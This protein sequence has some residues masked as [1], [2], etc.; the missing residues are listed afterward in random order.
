MSLTTKEIRDEKKIEI[1]ESIIQQ[2]TI[3]YDLPTGWQG[4]ELKILSSTFRLEPEFKKEVERELISKLYEKNPEKARAFEI[5]F[6]LVQGPI[7]D[8]KFFP[9]NSFSNF[10]KGIDEVYTSFDKKNIEWALKNKPLLEKN[11]IE[12]L[13]ADE[14]LILVNKLFIPKIDKKTSDSLVALLQSNPDKA[15]TIWNYLTLEKE[16]ARNPDKFLHLEN[17]KV[18]QEIQAENLETANKHQFA[19]SLYREISLQN[20][21]DEFF[22]KAMKQAR[23]LLKKGQIDDAI[24]TI[25][26]AGLHVVIQGQE[27]SAMFQSFLEKA[28]IFIYK[29]EQEKATDISRLVMQYIQFSKVSNQIALLLSSGQSNEVIGASV[30]SIDIFQENG[31][32]NETKFFN[33]TGVSFETFKNEGVN[34]FLKAIRRKALQLSQLGMKNSIDSIRNILKGKKID[35]KTDKILSSITELLGK[36]NDVEQLIN[37][38]WKI[39]GTEARLLKMDFYDVSG[40]KARGF[41]LNARSDA[42]GSFGTIQY[43]YL[44]ALINRVVGIDNTSILKNIPNLEKTTASKIQSLIR[45]YNISINFESYARAYAKSMEDYHSSMIKAF[46]N[47]RNHGTELYSKLKNTR[48]GVAPSLS[49]AI[50]DNFNDT[51]LPSLDI[52]N[53]E[54]PLALSITLSSYTPDAIKFNEAKTL[55][56]MFGENPP[57]ISPLLNLVNKMN[58]SGKEATDDYKGLIR[59]INTALYDLPDTRGE[60]ER[61][62]TDPVFWVPIAIA[63]MGRGPAAAAAVWRVLP[64]SVRFG[65]SAGATAY[66]AIEIGEG[67]AGLILSTSNKESEEAIGKMRSGVFNTGMGLLGLSSL[68]LMSKTAITASEIATLGLGSFVLS[69]DIELM[70]KEGKTKPLTLAFDL[71][72]L[73]PA[74]PLAVKGFKAYQLASF[75]ALSSEYGVLVE[76][77]IGTQNGKELLANQK[78]LEFLGKTP[79]EQEAILSALLSIGKN[80]AVAR[81]YYLIGVQNAAKNGLISLD[82]AQK[83]S[84]AILQESRL[85]VSESGLLALYSSLE[86]EGSIAGLSNAYKHPGADF[87]GVISSDVFTLISEGKIL[88]GGKQIPKGAI[89]NIEF[90][91]GGKGAFNLTIK[92]HNGETTSVIMKLEDLTAEQFGSQLVSQAGIVSPQVMTHSSGR[93]LTYLTPDGPRK[94]GLIEHMGNV[95]T[96]VDGVPVQISNMETM[97]DLSK[98]LE[99][100]IVASLKQ[101]DSLALRRIILR[102]LGYVQTG[103]IN[104]G[105]IDGTAANLPI[106]LGKIDQIGAERLLSSSKYL[107]FEEGITASGSLSEQIGKETLGIVMKSSDGSYYL[108][109][110]KSSIGRFDCE[111]SAMFYAAKTS[112]GYDFSPTVS[113]FARDS[114]SSIQSINSEFGQVSGYSTNDM[115]LDIFLGGQHWYRNVGSLPEFR[116]AIISRIAAHNGGPIGFATEGRLPKGFVSKYLSLLEDGKI[117]PKNMEELQKWLLSP[118]GGQSAFD[119]WIANVHKISSIDDSVRQNYISVLSMWIRQRYINGKDA[120]VSLPDGRISLDSQAAIQTFENLFAEGQATISSGK[121]FGYT[122]WNEIFRIISSL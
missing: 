69:K 101:T 26:I 1:A 28:R 91:F 114:L 108:M 84:I 27:N 33:L 102:S 112:A 120:F 4:D 17:K 46:R 68:K 20:I 107:L 106:M 42:V 23:I 47:M 52:Y 63:T 98:F 122:Y 7:L 78:I 80:E 6:L 81:L 13:V 9:D 62:L 89:A 86:I 66:G 92:L 44:L 24:S 45:N 35:S 118:T 50:E 55:G 59:E 96:V 40:L 115:F 74:V 67:T 18:L 85:D 36:A 43:N 82:S 99:T 11:G 65:L 83:L 90:K 38:I 29:G 39:R 77:T 117:S 37:S 79:A 2:V 87:L 121:G 116:Q 93:P 71:L 22:Q 30:A 104:V 105:A 60:V 109:S 19:L 100:P 54:I 48:T 119:E 10:S 56:E 32:F 41:L 49:K 53:D 5:E 70:I 76:A 16:L 61:L 111:T 3:R 72:L 64:E 21:N 31:K 95:S 25:N 113:R 12:V 57:S 15:A 73:L 34:S 88:I 110:I 51:Y 8:Q 94:F 75:K 14:S 58:Q 103:S 97:F